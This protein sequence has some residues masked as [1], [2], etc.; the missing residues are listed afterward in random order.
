MLGKIKM[1]YYADRISET[2]FEEEPML[3]E[4]CAVLHG[5]WWANKVGKMDLVFVTSFATHKAL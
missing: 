4:A 2:F 5:E 3:K 1:G